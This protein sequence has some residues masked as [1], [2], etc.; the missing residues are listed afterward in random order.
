VKGATKR[1]LLI[2]TTTFPRWPQDHD[3]PFVFELARRLTDSFEVTVIAPHI[4]GALENEQMNGVRIH[5]FRYAPERL[6]LLAYDGGIPSKLRRNPWLLLLVPG[7]L[8]ANLLAAYRLL[9]RIQPHVVHA[10]WLVPGGLVGSLLQELPAAPFRLVVTAHGADVHL[11]GGRL[12]S[13]LKRE[14]LRSADLITVVSNALRDT[15]EERLPSA[16]FAVAPM[17]V[18]LAKRFTPI[19]R[20]ADTP[21]LVFAGRLV[22][23]KGVADLLR[24]MPAILQHVPQTRL[25][26]VGDGPL[27][28]ELRALSRALDLD[29]AIEFVGSVPND[30]LPD[31]MRKAW[32]AVFPFRVAE[33]GDQEGLGLVAIEAMGCGIPVV[34]ADL[35]AVRDVVTHDQNGWLV[36]SGDPLA[37][38][39][40]VVKLLTDTQRRTRLAAQAR[41]DAL[42]RFDWSVVAQRYQKLLC[43]D[44]AN[45]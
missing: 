30:A 11:G 42:D 8:L 24:A 21:T 18:D 37:F 23:K 9:R 22:E 19:T 35:P 12:G 41:R 10:H 28:D 40:A 38:A 32:L 2:L 17:G 34:A 45:G 3:P 43:I 7:F 31:I 14:V 25:L 36:P 15:L 1:R 33:D 5:R 44:S 4:R 6:E 16:H 27:A 26:V 29:L 39:D 20:P 13:W